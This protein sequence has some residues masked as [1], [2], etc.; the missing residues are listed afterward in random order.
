M[1]VIKEFLREVL[2][3][4]VKMASINSSINSV[5]AFF[6]SNFFLGAVSPYLP[7]AAAAAAFGVSMRHYLKAYSLAYIESRNR[8]VNE[9]LTTARDNADKTNIVIALLFQDI[10]KKAKEISFDSLLSRWTFYGRLSIVIVLVILTT[11]ITPQQV[12]HSISDLIE[13]FSSGIRK[14]QAGL[15]DSNDIL[16]DSKLLELGSEEY[17]L[18]INPSSNEIDFDNEKPAER[19]S[20]ARNDFPSDTDAVLD[21]LNIES[22]PEEF[23]LVK[24]YSLKVRGG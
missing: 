20:F 4:R 21:T 24:A 13:S 22:L 16:S 3:E 7:V 14:L 18:S 19:R 15:K 9:M 11:F 23:E 10:A 2:A 1:E 5:L 17:R 6:V 12:S 8:S